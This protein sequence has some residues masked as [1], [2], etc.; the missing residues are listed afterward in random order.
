MNNKIQIT[1]CSFL[2]KLQHIYKL[3]P[4]NILKNE[5]KASG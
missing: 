3:E 1:S 2:S 4:I 5:Y